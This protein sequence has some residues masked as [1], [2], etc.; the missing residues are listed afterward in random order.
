MSDERPS[1]NSFDRCIT[2]KCCIPCGK[3]V[4]SEIILYLLSSAGIVLY[5]FSS[6]SSTQL[7]LKHDINTEF[8]PFAIFSNE[9][10]ANLD[11]SEQDSSNTAITVILK[12]F[13]LI[14]YIL[15]AQIEAAGRFK[16][17]RYFIIIHLISSQRKEH[18]AFLIIKNKIWVDHVFY[19]IG[20]LQL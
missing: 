10:K 7:H 20:I 8:L 11:L 17:L 4:V 3:Q 6:S 1:C 16:Q 14:F 2:G 15:Y 5:I 18:N 13:I 19:R 12:Y 9:L